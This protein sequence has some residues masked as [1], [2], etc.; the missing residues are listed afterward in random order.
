M[1]KHA[2]RAAVTRSRGAHSSRSTG[3]LERTCFGRQAHCVFASDNISWPKRGPDDDRRI[4]L[5]MLCSVGGGRLRCEKPQQTSPFRE[6]RRRASPSPKRPVTP[7][8]AGSSPV[9]PATDSAFVGLALGRL[10]DRF[11][12]DNEPPFRVTATMWVC[13]PSAYVLATK[14]LHGARLATNKIVRFAAP[15]NFARFA[16]VRRRGLLIPRSQVRNLPGPP[17]SRSRKMRRSA[18]ISTRA[19][20]HPRMRAEQRKRSTPRECGSNVRPTE[21]SRAST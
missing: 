21:P 10:I 5:T 17:Q 6:T 7:E 11:K 3:C 12:L 15:F 8:V 2:R 19:V 1:A 18:P 13:V 16:S 4:G 9:A 20:T 14:G